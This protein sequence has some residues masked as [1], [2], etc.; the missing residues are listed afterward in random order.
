MSPEEKRAVEL[1][2]QNM[3]AWRKL[4]TVPGKRAFNTGKKAL[5]IR[6]LKADSPCKPIHDL[7]RDRRDDK[8][9]AQLMAVAHTLSWGTEVPPSQRFVQEDAA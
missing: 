8:R 5:G 6:Y 3:A 2:A 4:Y 1:S 7:F 9:E